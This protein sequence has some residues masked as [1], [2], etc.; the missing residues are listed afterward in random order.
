ME[1]SVTL[2]WR[3]VTV[4]EDAVVAG[5]VSVALD[6]VGGG[7]TEALL[8]VAGGAPG[9]LVWIDGG[10]E[11]AE[12][13][14]VDSGGVADELETGGPG[15]GVED[16]VEAGGGSGVVDSAP[17]VVGADTG[18]EVERGGELGGALAKEETEEGGTA[19]VSVLEHWKTVIVVV[20]V[21][22]R[23]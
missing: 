14:V 21:S 10:A 6:S 13:L 2:D 1:D 22:G 18:T 8:S 5:G 23:H 15:G 19:E 4:V 3:D 7:T 17:D 11:A 12:G 16:S 20:A 9:L